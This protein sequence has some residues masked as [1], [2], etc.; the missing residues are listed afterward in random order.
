MLRNS[1]LVMWHMFSHE[2]MQKACVCEWDHT[3]RHPQA[4]WLV[5]RG[6]VLN[7]LL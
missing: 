5:Q 6:T 3:T 7:L 2:T 4:R 1:Y